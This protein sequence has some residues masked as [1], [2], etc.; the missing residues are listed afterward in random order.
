A[1]TLLAAS[2]LMSAAMT[3]APSLPKSTLIAFPMPD[4]APVTSAFLTANLPSAMRPPSRRHNSALSTLIPYRLSLTSSASN[5]VLRTSYFEPRTSN[6]VLRSSRRRPPLP[7]TSLACDNGPVS[8]LSDAIRRAGRTAPAPLGFAARAASTAAV[9]PTVL[10]IVR[11]NANDA[12]KAEEAVKKGA[13]AVTIEGADAGKVKDFAK[14]A[15]GLILGVRPHKTERE[16]ITSLREAGADFV[17]LDAESAMADA[18]LEENIGF[19]LLIRSDADDTRLRLMSDLNLD[20]L[21]PPPPDGSLTI[22]RLLELRRF[23]ALGR[24]PLL[25]EI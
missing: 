5:L 14:K 12:N 25:V 7:C 20:A 23:S 17:V 4:P 21:V 19:I 1:A 3:F 9:S 2:S 11:L 13:D 22:E 16:Q 10:C 15:P 6:L 24:A 18:L 8:K